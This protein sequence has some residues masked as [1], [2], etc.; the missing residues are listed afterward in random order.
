MKHFRTFCITPQPCHSHFCWR[1][2][3]IWPYLDVWAQNGAYGLCRLVW[4]YNRVNLS[5]SWPYM[6]VSIIW[7][8]SEL[9]SSHRSCATDI[10]VVDCCEFG[11]NWMFGLKMELMA[12]A[13][14]VCGTPEQVCCFTEL[15]CYYQWYETLLNC[16]HHTSAVPQPF[17]LLIAANLTLAGCLGSKWSLWP[18]P[19]WLV[20]QQS[21]SVFL[22]T[23]YNSIIDMKNF[24]TVFITP[25]LCHSHF[26]CWL[27][28]IWP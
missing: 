12:C 3:P 21:K 13:G 18:V 17:L 11:P 8:I 28:P 23:L 19:S 15:I 26:C 27:L 4:Q 9:S 22:L 10:F 14:L 20:M 25:Q 7:N 2:L 6:I 16:L 24:W 5:F 1:F